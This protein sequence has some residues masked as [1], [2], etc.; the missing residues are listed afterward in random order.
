MKILRVTSTVVALLVLV[1][2]CSAD[3]SWADGKWRGKG[4]W[5]GKAPSIGRIWSTLSDKQKM[6][7]DQIKLD[8][9]KKIQ[10]L[11]TEK[12][13]LKT[14]MLELALKSKPDETAIEKKRDELWMLKDKIR[15]QKRDAKRQLRKVLTPEQLNMVGP[16]G[17]RMGRGFGF[18]TWRAGLK[19]QR[20]K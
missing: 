10:P 17:P 12:W 3:Q 19:G 20:F 2:V 14:E 15:A 5:L 11:K 6:Q 8:F 16:F 18:G 4:K 7:V 1:A 13:K 9:L